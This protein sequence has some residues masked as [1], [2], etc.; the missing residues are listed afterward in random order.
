[1]MKN[2]YELGK[3]ICYDVDNSVAISNVLYFVIYGWVC[4]LILWAKHVT[5]SYFLLLLTRKL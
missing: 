5:V 3:M 2:R 4:R 1:M